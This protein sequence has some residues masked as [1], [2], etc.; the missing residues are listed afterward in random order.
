MTLQIQA[1]PA[2]KQLLGAIPELPSDR[3]TP[4]SGPPKKDPLIAHGWDYVLYLGIF[5]IAI[6][7]IAIVGAVSPR[8]EHALYFA[9]AISVVL[10]AFLFTV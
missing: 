8:V 1:F 4:T 9:L 3:E 5:A 10:I 2:P 7:L 6:A